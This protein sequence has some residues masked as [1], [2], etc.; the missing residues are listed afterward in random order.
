MTTLL[1]LGSHVHRFK[2][3]TPPKPCSWDCFSIVSS[4]TPPHQTLYLRSRGLQ[5]QGDPL[6]H[7]LYLE[8]HGH[9]H[10]GD[11]NFQTL[12]LGSHIHRL[13]EPPCRPPWS[14]QSQVT[15]PKSCTWGHM[16][17][18]SGFPHLK[19]LYLGSHVQSQGD[20]L[21]DP[22]HVHSLLCDVISQTLHLWSQVHRLQ[23]KPPSETM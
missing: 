1:Y 10:H 5:S 3:D 23:C 2:G 16:S 4:V 18:V 9:N 7:I 19:S 12:Y 14:P 8:P 15:H 6:S 20:S 22:A 21:P 13:R 17:T 11:P